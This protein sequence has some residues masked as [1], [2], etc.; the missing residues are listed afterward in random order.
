MNE[1]KYYLQ[2]VSGSFT[3][4]DKDGQFDVF[5]DEPLIC[6][7]VDLNS[8]TPTQLFEA[9]KRSG[10]DFTSF[11]KSEGALSMENIKITDHSSNGLADLTYCLD[12]SGDLAFKDN[13][14]VIIYDHDRDAEEYTFIEFSTDSVDR[15]VDFIRTHS[16][17]N[18]TYEVETADPI[19]FNDLASLLGYRNNIL[20]FLTDSGIPIKNKYP[21]VEVDGK[22]TYPKSSTEY[23]AMFTVFIS[24]PTFILTK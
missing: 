12:K 4:T 24:L 14:D 16:F 19:S 9:V 11:N 8:V 13:D 23:N 5:H 22:E 17:I 3:W 1:K 20:N 2:F 6:T 10:S 15:L 21:F 18:D 7:D